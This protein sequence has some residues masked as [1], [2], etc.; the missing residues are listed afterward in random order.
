[1]PQ[2]VHLQRALSTIKDARKKQLSQNGH[3]FPNV[4]LQVSFSFPLP[5]WLLKVPNREFEIYDATVAK[6]SLK[7]ASSSLSIFFAITSV[8]GV[9]RSTD[10]WIW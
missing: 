4:Y 1:M 7:I 8:R 2:P 9:N 6:T 5:S 10:R 3:H